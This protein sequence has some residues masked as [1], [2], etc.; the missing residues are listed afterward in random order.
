M[1]NK[2]KEV[3][4]EMRDEGYAVIWL[5]PA[6]L[7]ELGVSRE[8]A[9]KILYELFYKEFSEEESEPSDEGSD[10]EWLASAGRG[11]DEDYGGYSD[12]Y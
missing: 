4:V 2:I 10:A 9:E 8:D 3:I 6:I 1:Q 5:T 11:T 12:Y 7:R